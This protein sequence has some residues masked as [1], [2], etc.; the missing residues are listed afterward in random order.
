MITLICIASINLALISI[1]RPMFMV[2]I[3]TLKKKSF[4][5]PNIVETTISINSNVNF[6][7]FILFQLDKQEISFLFCAK[8]ENIFERIFICEFTL[9]IRKVK[10]DIAI[11]YSAYKF[12]TYYVLCQNSTGQGNSYGICFI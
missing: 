8:K 3:L 12:F 7:H 2:A 1:A 5:S 9:Q 11:A 4:S 6:H 10:K